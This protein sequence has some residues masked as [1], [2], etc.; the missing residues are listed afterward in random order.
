MLPLDNRLAMRIQRY[1]LGDRRA[2]PNARRTPFLFL[3][4]TGNPISLSSVNNIF[5]Q[6]VLRHPEFDGLLTPHVMRHTHNDELAKT[7]ERDGCSRDLAKE[8][9]NYLNGWEPNS[10][11]GTRYTATYIKTK[12]DEIAPAHQSR[13][14]DRETSK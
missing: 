4:R 11:Q 1:I 12:A 14:F 9:V 10:S 13:I 6:V 3:A 5:D 7:L 2:L 8:I